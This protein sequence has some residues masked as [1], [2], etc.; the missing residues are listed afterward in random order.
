MADSG[1]STYSQRPTRRSCCSWSLSPATTSSSMPP[2]AHWSQGWPQRQPPSS[3]RAE[4]IRPSSQLFQNRTKRRLRSKRWR[5]S[6]MRRRS[7]QR[8]TSERW[9][10][11]TF[12]ITTSKHGGSTRRQSSRDAKEVGMNTE[13]RAQIHRW[14]AFAVLAVSFFMTII[15][16]TIVNVALPTIGR[17]LHFSESDLQWVVT[18]YG[19][20]FGGF[21]LLGGRAA[22]LLGRR[23]ILMLGLAVFTAASLGAG[24]AT[25]GGFLIAMRGLQGL[26]AAVILPAAL[27]IVM[28]MFPER[29]AQQGARF[30][31]RHRSS[32]RG[33]EQVAIFLGGGPLA[34]ATRWRLIPV[35]A[36]GQL[37]FCAYAWDDKTQTFVLHAV[38]VLTLRGAQI[39][40]ITAFLAPDAF[41]GFDLPAAVPA[42][43]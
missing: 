6:D 37:A 23:R 3:S 30:V 33:R 5:H 31:G 25:S 39:Q 38:N 18:A 27:S 35:R 41:R 16:L 17:D 1:S 43:S 28:N 26:G 15:D 19:I 36:N 11:A 14:R 34:G 2:P 32:S 21:L 9:I 7:A 10:A 42:N 13:L 29:R 24:L 22:D 4:P 40:E 8:S 20:T 12:R